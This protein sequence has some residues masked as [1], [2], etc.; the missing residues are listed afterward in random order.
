MGG[1]AQLVAAGKRDRT[2]ERHVAAAIDPASKLL[3]TDAA[4]MKQNSRRRPAFFLE[5]RKA[6]IVRIAH[7]QNERQPAFVREL[8][9]AA[10]H[11]ALHIAGRKVVVI[12]QAH[13]AESARER[14]S[15]HATKR[16]FHLIAPMRR[17]VRMNA[18][19]HAHFR[20]GN[21]LAWAAMRPPFVGGHLARG[22]LFLGMSCTTR[23]FEYLGEHAQRLAAPFVHQGKRNIAVLV[24][25]YNRA[26]EI[27][28]LHRAAR[29]RKR[30]IRDKGQM[31]M[32]I[33]NRGLEQRI[34][35]FDIAPTALF[36]LA[37]KSIAK[38][39]I[40]RRAFRVNAPE[41]MLSCHFPRCVRFLSHI[42]HLCSGYKPADWLLTACNQS[43]NSPLIDLERPASQR[44][45]TRRLPLP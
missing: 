23:C 38:C 11:V 19:R 33:G 27:H 6:V 41:N 7:M 10:K 31:R 2:A 5:N 32:G 9:L 18:R 37:E 14:M 35:S 13:F 12:V 28:T 21:G 30:S 3:G 42:V 26:D 20:N 15:Q 36:L 29:K 25:V 34:G 16:C 39:Q 24:G 17:I 44:Q 45:P 43:R 40:A 22:A 4:A 8:D 1:S